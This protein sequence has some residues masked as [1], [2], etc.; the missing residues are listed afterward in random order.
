MGFQNKNQTNKRSA[1]P[2][3]PKK[4]VVSQNVG[5]NIGAYGIINPNKWWQ[6]TPLQSVKVN[7]VANQ[8]SNLGS[9]VIKS[10]AADDNVNN[11]NRLVGRFDHIF[12]NPAGAGNFNTNNCTNIKELIQMTQK[13]FKHVD[14][15]LDKSNI[16]TKMRENF[17]KH[18]TKTDIIQI[19]KVTTKIDNKYNTNVVQPTSKKLY[20]NYPVINIVQK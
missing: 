15:I 17:N 13:F 12:N 19:K 9:E 4:D 10:A 6:T 5:L 16:F 8:E 20:T 14:S 18:F 11:F 7:E 2:I 1:G 3:T